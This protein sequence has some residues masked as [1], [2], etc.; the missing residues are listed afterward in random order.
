MTLIKEKELLSKIRI[1]DLENCFFLFEEILESIFTLEIKNIETMKVRLLEF[2]LVLSRTLVER[3][4]DYNQVIEINFRLVTDMADL[5]NVEEASNVAHQVF[6]AYIKS[7]RIR[8]S[9][10]E[11]L[12][13]QVKQL[14]LEKY[15][16]K[17]TLEELAKTVYISPYYLSHL[18]KEQEGISVMDYLTR[19]RIEKAKTLLRN[20]RYNIY[21]ISEIIGYSEPSYFSRVFRKKEGRTPSQFRKFG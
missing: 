9:N 6:Q 13:K 18:F 12:I 17:L 21:E 5:Q 2:M 19:V 8:P 7:M 3:G 16:Q 10:N 4:A 1:G 15:S 14:I 20:Q 11:N